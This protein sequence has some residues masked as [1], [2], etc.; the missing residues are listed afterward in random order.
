MES[1]S[2]TDNV[3]SLY[4]QYR[5]NLNRY[6]LSTKRINR[7][8]VCNLIEAIY[9]LIEQKKPEIIFCESPKAGCELSKLM[10]GLPRLH[11]ELYLKTDYTL[12]TQKQIEYENLVWKLLLHSFTV[13]EDFKVDYWIGLDLNVIDY[14]L[15][16]KNLNYREGA[17]GFTY[18]IHCPPIVTPRSLVGAIC[19][20]FVYRKLGAS[21]D[22]T[23]GLLIRCLF[24]SIKNVGWLLP[25]QDQCIVCERPV[26]INL[27]RKFLPTT[28]DEPVITFSDDYSLFLI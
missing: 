28:K 20:S 6:L 9:L 1:F 26:K 23:T 5:Y 13:E 7:P 2:R 4:N 8:V 11:K 21:L 14:G 18:H 25:Y 17:T 15:F 19:R 10:S 22:T 24:E 27:D 16:D 12:L 3:L